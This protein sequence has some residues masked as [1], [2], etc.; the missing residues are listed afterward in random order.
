MRLRKEKLLGKQFY[1]NAEFVRVGSH[2]VLVNHPGDEL[3]K[4]LRDPSAMRDMQS[5]VHFLCSQ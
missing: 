1:R 5:R 3:A 4:L 2:G